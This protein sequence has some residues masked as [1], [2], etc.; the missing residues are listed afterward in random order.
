MNPLL[1]VPAHGAETIELGR[2]DVEI[3]RTAKGTAGN[4]SGPRPLWPA[5]R[6]WLLGIRRDD[7]VRIHWRK[8]WRSMCDD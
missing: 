8:V 3:V 1:E 2:D 5:A 4:P 7:L 6:G